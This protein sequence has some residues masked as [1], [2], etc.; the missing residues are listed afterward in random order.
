MS[1][2]RAAPALA[3]I[4]LIVAGVS[5]VFL[6]ATNAMATNAT[7]QPGG[8][9][10]YESHSPSPSH[11]RSV[12]PSP[13]GTLPTTG[14]GASDLAMTGLASVGAGVVLVSMWWVWQA[15]NRAQVRSRGRVDRKPGH[16][17][18]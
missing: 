2:R 9:S 1:L 11:S 14:S 10:G 15:L 13:S 7:A 8:G 12:T 5:G 16:R 4:A 3:L 17:H 18:Q 6:M